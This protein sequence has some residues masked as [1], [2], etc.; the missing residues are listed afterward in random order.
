MGNILTVPAVLDGGQRPEALPT[1]RVAR[2][3][4]SVRS[5]AFIGRTMKRRGPVNTWVVGILLF[6]GCSTVNFQG[7]LPRASD[8]VESRSGLQTA[9]GGE[10]A[11]PA[12]DGRSPLTSTQAATVALRNNRELRAEL[13]E[14]A[15]ARA[16][17]VQA[18]LLP[19]PVVSLA[20]RLPLQD[21]TPTF[22]AGII[23]QFTDIWLRPYREGAAQAALDRTVL[24]ASDRAL[25][26]VARV[27]QAHARVAY[28]QQGIEL[29]KQDL[30]LLERSI[31]TTEGRVRAGEATA[32]DVN[33]V[34]QQLLGLQAELQQ[35][36]ASLEKQKRALLLE[37]GLA[38]GATDWMAETDTA[39]RA[40]EWAR[41]SET[42]LVERI[43][44]QRLDVLAAHYEVETRR[45][46]LKASQWRKGKVGVDGGASFESDNDGSELGPAVD[47]TVPFF[48]TGSAQVEKAKA[49]V[50]AA[51]ARAEQVE[52]NAVG[53][54]RSALVE[55][56]RASQLIE[57]Y[58]G[59]VLTLA[60]DNLARAETTVRSGT[61]DQTV[62]LE[63]Q[64]ELIEARRT[65]NRLEG[66][67]AEARQALEY[68]VGGWV[69]A[70]RGVMMDARKKTGS[71]P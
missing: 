21:G 12:W 38:D 28:G 67:I 24:S 27:G 32:L 37:M 1:E 56:R 59:Q 34:R 8:L 55:L 51:E 17:L 42:E 44:E 54:A 36:Q 18:G 57:F 20:F 66:D 39:G 22:D 23:Q 14:I 46:E 71:Q 11:P 30:G 35:E 63:A 68:A 40:D 7:D 15:A 2:A 65:L 43:R 48:D 19:N 69:D 41:L 58:R 13:E 64:R 70:Q 6:S 50:R 45:Q 52:Q 16:D 33:R 53:E 47:L 9:W 26:L 10:N 5:V 4:A 49:L 61:A 62:L 25:R 3:R 31:A 29:T 60:Q